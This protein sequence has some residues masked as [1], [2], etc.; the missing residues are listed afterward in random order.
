MRTPQTYTRPAHPTTHHLDLD[1]VRRLLWEHHPPH[2]AAANENMVIA[3]SQSLVTPASQR[4]IASSSPPPIVGQHA[5]QL[6]VMPGLMHD[7]HCYLH[8]ASP[9]LMKEALL[10]VGVPVVPCHTHLCVWVCGCRQHGVPGSHT[11][12]TYC[13]ADPAQ[14]GNTC[15][16]RL[17]VDSPWQIHPGIVPEPVGRC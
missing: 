7:H 1:L 15:V 11:L 6:F 12:S 14:L 13:T 8:L 9:H 16:P 3:G 17:N 10:W 2:L 5:K 4:G